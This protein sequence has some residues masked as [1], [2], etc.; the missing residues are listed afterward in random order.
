MRS[1]THDANGGRCNLLLGLGLGLT[2]LLATG[3]RAPAPKAAGAGTPVRVAQVERA[4]VPVTVE[5]VGAVESPNS[6]E[7]LSRV[8]GQV[9]ARHFEEGADVGAGTLLFTVDPAPFE[10][11]LRE[12]EGTLAR[13]EAD[14]SFKQTEAARYQFLVDKGAVSKSDFERAQSEAM[15]LAETL[16][17]ARAAVEQA[18]LNLSYCQIRAPIAGRTGAFIVNQGAT[19]EAFRTPLVVINQITPIN[20][21]FSLPERYVTELR[22]LL[23]GGDVPVEAR[24][25]ATGETVGEGRLTFLDNRVDEGSGMIR[26]KA[27]FPNQTG[28]LWPGLFVTATVRLRPAQ[29]ALTVPADAVFATA[30][31]DSVFVVTEAGIAEPRAV[32]VERR[33][34]AL[35]VIG[36]GVK[37]GEKVVTDGHGKLRPG[38]KVRV[39]SEPTGTPVAPGGRG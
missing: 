27:L 15:A 17:A 14:Y 19:V 32:K 9:K 3:C 34:G 18:R 12:A 1:A 7:V 39:V 36:E 35:A 26:V 31:G 23:R 8:A 33:Q 22:A 10:E 13:G 11:K 2:A 6:V 24:I 20:V 4:Q 38:A 16:R 21:R 29:E 30:R 28:Q 25:A 5:A 37:A